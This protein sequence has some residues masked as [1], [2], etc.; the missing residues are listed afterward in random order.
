[1]S[2]ETGQKGREKLDDIRREALHQKLSKNSSTI[3]DCSRPFSLLDA[4][5][6]VSRAVARNLVASVNR[7]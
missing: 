3:N 4:N 1:M 7:L 6:Q 5:P 2:P